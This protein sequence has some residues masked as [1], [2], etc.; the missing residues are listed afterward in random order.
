MGL[1]YDEEASAAEQMDVVHEVVDVPAESAQQWLEAI[2]RLNAIGE[3]LA[4]KLIDLHRDCGS[5]NGV[6]DDVDEFDDR[7]ARRAE[8][9]CET[10][11]T[12]AG[13]FNVEYPS[14]IGGS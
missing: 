9:G 7:P 13:H 14:E 11:E 10:I 12:I 2:R 5:G 1:Y 4:R 6:C 3:P 8:W